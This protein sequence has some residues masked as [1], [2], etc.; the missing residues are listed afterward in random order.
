MVTETRPPVRIGVVGFGTGGLHF[1]APFIEAADGVELEVAMS[2]Q[3]SELTG[4]AIR[5]FSVYEASDQDS[6]VG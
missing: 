1:H 4:A 6:G 3:D 5:R 2:S